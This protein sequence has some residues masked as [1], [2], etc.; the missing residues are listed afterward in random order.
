MYSQ[1]TQS[2]NPQNPATQTHVVTIPVHTDLDIEQ[3]LDVIKS[4][5]LQEIANEI[6]SLGYEANIDEK[7][8]TAQSVPQKR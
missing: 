7:Q 3:L 8:V 4:P 1:S 5:I 6:K 2:S